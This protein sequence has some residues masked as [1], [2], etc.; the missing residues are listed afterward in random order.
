MF[1]HVHEINGKRFYHSHFYA[2][3]NNTA[4]SGMPVNSHSHTNNQFE[5]IGNFNEIVWSTAGFLSLMHYAP[6]PLCKLQIVGGEHVVYPLNA[7]IP[8]LRAPPLS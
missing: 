6:T 5:L 3:N 8:H 4:D 1:Y 2:A 7:F